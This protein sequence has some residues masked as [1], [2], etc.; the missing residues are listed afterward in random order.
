MVPG[1][2]YWLGW[3]YLDDPEHEGYHCV[4]PDSVHVGMRPEAT[5]RAVE[6][7]IDM[8]YSNL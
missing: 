5:D 1:L 3:W 4:D 7:F 6:L 2:V 8:Q